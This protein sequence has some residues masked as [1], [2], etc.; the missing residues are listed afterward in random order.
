MITTCL[1]LL[2]HKQ[3]SLSEVPKF[4]S[5]KVYFLIN[6]FDTDQITQMFTTTQLRLISLQCQPHIKMLK[7]KR[8]WTLLCVAILIHVFILFIF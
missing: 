3:V 1:S 6:G 2:P 5:V 7:T 4:L 8:I